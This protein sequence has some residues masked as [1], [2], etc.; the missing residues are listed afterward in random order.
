MAYQIWLETSGS[1]R[2]V[3]YVLTPIMLTMDVKN[4]TLVVNLS[5]AAVR[6]FVITGLLVAQLVVTICQMPV[7][8]I[9]VSELLLLQLKALDLH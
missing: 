8:I 6:F 3:Y 1:G 5:C 4:Q 7:V 9:L 2:R